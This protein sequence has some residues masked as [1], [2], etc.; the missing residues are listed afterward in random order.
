VAGLR[1]YVAQGIRILTTP[2]ARSVIE[3]VAASR[4][5]MYPDAL[6]HT[7]RS[8]EIETVGGKKWLDDGTN[9]AELHDF[10]STDHVAQILMAYFP[11]QRVLF[12]A[13]VWD[14][15]SRDL[16]I[17]GS[18]AVRMAEKIR[19]L[20]LTVERIVPVHGIPTTMEALERG[21]AVR[22]KYR[23]PAS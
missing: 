3:Q 2:D 5:T 20:G 8:P 9:R 22:E 21:L 23:G 1:P 12:E 4:R 7:P 15:L 10:G 14:P 13:D 16:D 17:A 19:E 6:S 18:D 11:R